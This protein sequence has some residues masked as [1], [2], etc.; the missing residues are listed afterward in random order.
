MSNALRIHPR[1]NVVVATLDL[2]TGAAVELPEGG[3]RLSLV[4]REP[5]PFGHKVAIVR[6]PQG[7]S[8]IKYGA[9]IGLAFTDIMPGE[10]VHTHN[11]HS[12]RGAAKNGS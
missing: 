1:D 11:L 3:E 7:Q 10:H 6:I 8:V 12:V 5:I 2:P 4:T 9:S